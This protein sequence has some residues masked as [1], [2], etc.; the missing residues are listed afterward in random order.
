MTEVWIL[1]TRKISLRGAY[2]SE[3][4]ALEAA[5]DRDQI[6][7]PICVDNTYSEVDS[8]YSE[9]AIWNGG[10]AYLRRIERRES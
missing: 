10:V 8:T 4:K 3:D 2:R 7:G 1:L 9:K 5:Q 6:I